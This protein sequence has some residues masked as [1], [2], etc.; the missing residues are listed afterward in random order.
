MRKNAGSGSSN[1]YGSTTLPAPKGLIIWT[2]FMGIIGGVVQP[3]MAVRRLRHA[4]GTAL[5]GILPFLPLPGYDFQNG[6]LSGLGLYSTLLPSRPLGA[7]RRLWG[8][9]LQVYS[10]SCFSF[11]S[12]SCLLLATKPP[13]SFL[14]FLHYFLY[15]LWLANCD[16]TVL[17]LFHVCD[18][19]IL[20]IPLLS[21]KVFEKTTVWSGFCCGLQFVPLLNNS[22]SEDISSYF[23]S[24]I[25]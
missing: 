22:D 18:E 21:Q 13:F 23:S 20:F 25:Q 14:H 1:H 16:L 17:L 5:R 7:W 11:L 19:I 15:L 9:A 2:G 8:S 6:V 12:Q 24:S 4:R 3:A 10:K